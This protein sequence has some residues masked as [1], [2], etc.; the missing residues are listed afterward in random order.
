MVNGIDEA[1]STNA[2]TAEES[3]TVSRCEC[4]ATTAPSQNT[5]TQVGVTA[6]IA[7]ITAVTTVASTFPVVS[8]KNK[9]KIEYTKISVS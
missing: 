1:V 5:S 9:N 7:A 4:D 8:F 3:E 6:A 2:H